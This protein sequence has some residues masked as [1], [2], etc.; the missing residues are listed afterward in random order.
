MNINIYKDVKD[1]KS[2]NVSIVLSNS[3]SLLTYSFKWL[4]IHL[5]TLYKILEMNY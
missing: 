5:L 2:V 1:F 4:K 3:A